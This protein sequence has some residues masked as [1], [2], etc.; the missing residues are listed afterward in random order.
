[1]HPVRIAEILYPDSNTD[2]LNLN[3]SLL[4]HQLLKYETKIQQL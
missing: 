3:F 4:R 2:I 1:M